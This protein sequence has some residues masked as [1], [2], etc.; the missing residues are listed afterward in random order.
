MQMMRSIEMR[1][2]KNL[3]N[4]KYES[5]YVRDNLRIINKVGISFITPQ[6]EV[7][8]AASTAEFVGKIQAHKMNNHDLINHGSK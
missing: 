6:C 1:R 7:S 4:E 8:L 3:T 2:D 5:S